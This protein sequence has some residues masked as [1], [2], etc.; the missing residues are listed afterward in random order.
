MVGKSYSF[1]SS[2]FD[3]CLFYLW[4]YLGFYWLVVSTTA[5]FTSSVAYYSFILLYWANFSSKDLIVFYKSSAVSG[6]RTLT[7][8]KAFLIPISWAYMTFFLG[9][10]SFYAWGYTFLFFLFFLLTTSTSK[11]WDFLDWIKVTPFYFFHWVSSD[12]LFWISSILNFYWSWTFYFSSSGLSFLQYSINVSQFLTWATYFL[13]LTTGTSLW[14]SS[15]SALFL[16]LSLNLIYSYFLLV[17]HST[18]LTSLCCFQYSLPLAWKSSQRSSIE[19]LSF[20]ILISSWSF[21]SVFCSLNF[22]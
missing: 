22:L 8:S 14:S 12:N 10:A 5:S 21:F 19:S 11:S 17:N 1:I 3:C 6:Q 20:S 15:Y 2:L 13:G 18:C 4:V 16:S 9:F 7:Y